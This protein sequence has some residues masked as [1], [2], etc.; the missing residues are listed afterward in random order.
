MVDE[1]PRRGELLLCGRC[2]APYDPED[3]F[4]RKCGGPVS[5]IRLPAVRQVY[6]PVPWHP[7]SQVIVRGAAVVAAGALTEFVVRRIARRLFRPRN[8]LP[9]L[10]NVGQDRVRLVKRSDD[11]EVEPDAQIE[12]ETIVLRQI[13]LRRNRRAVD[14]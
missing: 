7:P 12:S 5:N 13:R 2:A 9:V 4:C 6:S 8:L 10:R 11:A 1:A 14:E 3:R